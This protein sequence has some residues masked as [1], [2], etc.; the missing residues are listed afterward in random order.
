MLFSFPKTARFHTRRLP[1]YF[2]NYA[3]VIDTTMFPQRSR[4]VGPPHLD[5]A[6]NMTLLASKQPII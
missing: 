3:D 5:L 1:Q 6:I 4:I 2:K